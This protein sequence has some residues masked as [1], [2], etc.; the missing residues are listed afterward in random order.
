[1]E[2]RAVV[3]GLPEALTDA[4][5]VAIHVAIH[6]VTT[7]FP[8]GERPMRQTTQVAIEHVV[9]TSPRSYEQVTSALEARM[10]KADRVNEL[11]TQ[12]AAS[13]VSWDQVRQKIESQMGASGFAIFNKV[14]QGQL[15]ALAGKPRRVSQYTLGNPLLAIE[16]IQHEPEVALYAPLRLAV[17]EE[18][19]GGTRIAYDRF[20]SVLAP[21]P[22][23]E[24]AAIADIVQRKLDDLVDSALRG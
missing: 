14:E 11:L 6:M 20:T 4:T 2:H 13:R 22:H 23:P 21:Y 18:D 12:L 15:L 8:A 5:A 19:R 16:M 1:V 24:I 17:F 3:G 10:S 7:G 9:V